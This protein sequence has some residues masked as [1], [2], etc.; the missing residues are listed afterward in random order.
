[1]LPVLLVLALGATALW[2]NDAA[3]PM[4]EALAALQ[5]DDAVR[6][7]V[8]GPWLV[9]RPAGSGAPSAGMILYPGGRVDARAYAPLAHSLAGS[10]YLVVVVPMPL[11]LAILG[12]NEAA[13]VI[14]AYPETDSW[15]VGGH[16]LGGAM[17][18]RFALQ[19]LTLV[20]GLFLMAAYPAA[21]D[22][23]AGNDIAVVSV[24]GTEDG[25]AT[26]AKIEASR[27]LLP[28]STS[29][30]AIAGGNHAQFGWYGDQ[31]GDNPALVSREEQQA[32][33]LEAALELMRTI[34][35]R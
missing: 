34:G 15:A 29:W 21:T 30:V 11:N 35:G 18:A 31:A 13:E 19:H 16:S 4:A 25:L 14:R 5:S 26:P 1:M 32:Q 6:V 23:L 7:E 3:E 12:A 27:P 24:F 17:A 9:F 28:A 8:G 2:A 10:G 33:L 20:D 22:S